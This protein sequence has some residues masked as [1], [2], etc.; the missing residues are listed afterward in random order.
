MRV[1]PLFS[2]KIMKRELYSLHNVLIFFGMPGY[3]S[4]PY[5]LKDINTALR[6]YTTDVFV[7]VFHGD[8]RTAFSIMLLEVIFLATPDLILSVFSVCG[9]IV[10]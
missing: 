5:P 4:Q 10:D 2:F 9:A 8:G 1:F 7:F 6:Y 3:F